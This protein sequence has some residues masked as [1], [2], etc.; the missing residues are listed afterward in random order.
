M[1]SRTEVD[2]SCSDVEIIRSLQARTSNLP[3]VVTLD[4]VLSFLDNRSVGDGQHYGT[5]LTADSP[6]VLR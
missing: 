6:H 3:D 5:I 2:V 1:T 4:Y